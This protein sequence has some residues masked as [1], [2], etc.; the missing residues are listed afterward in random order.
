MLLALLYRCLRYSLAMLYL[1]HKAPAVIIAYAIAIRQLRLPYASVFFADFATRYF[2]CQ[3]DAALIF[4]R[5]V[6]APC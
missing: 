3:L 4:F 1:R 2:C 6:D 5:H